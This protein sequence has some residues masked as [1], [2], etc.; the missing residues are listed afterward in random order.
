MLSLDCMQE[1]KRLCVDFLSRIE[2]FIPCSEYGNEIRNHRHALVPIEEFIKF[3]RE[4][5]YMDVPNITRKI[6]TIQYLQYIKDFENIGVID[7]YQMAYQTETSRNLRS[8]KIKGNKPNNLQA[9]R[10]DNGSYPGDKE[11]CSNSVVSVQFHHIILDDPGVQY[12]KKDLFNLAFYY[13]LA[14]GE[15]FIRLD[16]PVEDD[17]SE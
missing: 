3:F 2:S 1:N 14:I 5:K 7:V 15:D 16:K 9:G 10:A 17:D 12:G 8:R 4:F 11:F 6:V 13:P